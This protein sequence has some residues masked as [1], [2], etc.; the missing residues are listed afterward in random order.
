MKDKEH[1]MIDCMAK[2]IQP[3]KRQLMYLFYIFYRF[4]KIKET[5]GKVKFPKVLYLISGRATPSSES[6]KKLLE[7]IL[8][9][10]SV[11]NKDPVGSQAM[12]L[13]YIPNYSVSI[14]EYLVSACDTSQ[15]ISAPGTEVRSKQ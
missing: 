14:A 9:V 4:I 8:K 6:G 15:H 2:R 12:R 13:V 5:Q 3:S 10:A 7:L 11:I 1:L